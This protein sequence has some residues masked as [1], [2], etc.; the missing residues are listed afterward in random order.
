LFIP[1]PAASTGKLGKGNNLISQCQHSS[2]GLTPAM[3]LELPNQCRYRFS[4]I[5][6]NSISLAEYFNTTG[7][8]N[9]SEYPRFT[10]SKNKDIVQL[11]QYISEIEQRESRSSGTTVSSL[12]YFRNSITASFSASDRRLGP[13]VLAPELERPGC[14][15]S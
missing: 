12:K 7:S 1:S 2:Q 15:V 5:W 14:L 11:F 13:Q 8:T 6:G 3:N 10:K 4:G 9:N